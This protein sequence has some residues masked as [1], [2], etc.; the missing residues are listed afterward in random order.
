MIL[1]LAPALPATVWDWFDWIGRTGANVIGI[2]VL[3]LFLRFLGVRVVS[4]VIRGAARRA[5]RARLEDEDLVDR[6]VDTL[7]STLR[8]SFT[9]ILGLLGSA[10]ILEQFNVEISAL[11]A[12]VGV[13]GLTIGLGSQALIRDVINGMFILTEGQYAVGDIVRV[14]GVSGQV[15]EITPRRTVLR[16]IDGNVHVIP[17]GEIKVATNMTQGFSRI[18]LDIGVAYEENLD[19]VIKVINEVCEQLAADRRD[20]F[21]TTPKVVRVNGLG[22]NSVDIKIVGD[23]KVYTQWELTGELRKRLKDRFDVDGIEI[24][25]RREVQVPFSRSRNPKPNGAPSRAD[26]PTG[27][28]E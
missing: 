7:L 3:L 20:D 14:A 15:V 13:V 22:D 2:V 27:K 24:P 21:V 26:D 17:N 28:D 5:G 19:H 23:V 10:L 8:W 12:G 11:L 25:Y 18:N 9:L 1:E 4:R 6:R 16:D